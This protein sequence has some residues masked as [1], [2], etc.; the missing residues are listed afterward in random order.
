MLKIYNKLLKNNSYS[1]FYKIKIN[2]FIDHCL[3]GAK[4][5]GQC[6]LSPA[7]SLFNNVIVDIF[8][9]YILISLLG[10]DYVIVL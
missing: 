2:K 7:I 10:S 6:V 3:Q 4:Q 8:K 5:P 9:I 1:L